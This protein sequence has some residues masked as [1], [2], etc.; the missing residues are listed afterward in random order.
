[1]HQ[2]RP[3]HEVPPFLCFPE[4]KEQ[5]QNAAHRQWESPFP[6]MLCIS[7]LGRKQSTYSLSLAETLPHSGAP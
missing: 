6:V 3:D 2:V 5:R 7:H 4:T 1:M